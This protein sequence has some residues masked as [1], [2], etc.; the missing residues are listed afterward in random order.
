M[1]NDYQISKDGTIFQIKEDGTISKLAKLE[2]G[3][4]LVSGDSTASQNNTSGKGVLI[5]FLITFAISSLVLGILYSQANDRYY[6]SLGREYALEQKVT[7]LEEELN[8]LRQPSP[9]QWTISYQDNNYDNDKYNGSKA[10]SSTNNTLR[11]ELEYADI[12]ELREVY[13]EHGGDD[14]YVSARRDLLIQALE[15]MLSR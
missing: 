10:K 8:S 15:E 13:A 14:P 9:S 2:D 12:E 4:V 7:T 6:S 1:N 11:S 3:K 5:F